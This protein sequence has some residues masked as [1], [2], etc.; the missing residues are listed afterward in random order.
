MRHCDVSST[1]RP[2]YD[3][4]VAFATRAPSVHNTQP[5]LWR[6]SRG[7]LE[8][9]ADRARQLSRADPDGR[10]LLLSC[11]AALH[12]LRVAAAALG[13]AADVRHAPDPEYPGLLASIE[14]S[15]QD[16][17]E[18]AARL[19][20][21]L[22]QRQ[23]D[24]RRFSPPPLAREQSRSLVEAGSGWG[25]TVTW[26]EDEGVR[27]RLLR[28]TAE[29]DERQ[30][31]DPA[32]ATEVDTWVRERRHDGVA[33]TNVPQA[34]AIGVAGDLVPRRF[35]PGTLVD[36]SQDRTSTPPGIVVIATSSDDTL[37]RVRAG[38]AL[39]AV[40]LEATGKNLAA[41]PL[42]QATEVD[43]TRRLLATRELGDRACPQILLC[44]GWPQA[45]CPPPPYTAR[46]PVAR[47]LL[48]AD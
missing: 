28:L 29:A 3:E 42:S 13:W 34:S 20:T 35:P 24:R 21:C 45:D 1:A 22:M 9:F 12:H 5:W 32:Y 36:G 14:F 39:S 38:E 30:R 41:V 33:A 19:L 2:P 18:E 46:R 17:S 47:V 15:P 25:A 23:T 31:R 40:W 48:R 37:S 27:M 26:V 6:A 16:V 8:L 10:D 44:V 4:M 43:D 7:G 11:G